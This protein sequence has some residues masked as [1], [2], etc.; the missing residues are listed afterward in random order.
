M[1]WDMGGPSPFVLA[2][3]RK[4]RGHLILM[5]WAI[6]RAHQWLSEKRAKMQHLSSEKELICCIFLSKKL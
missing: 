4:L 2:S 5:P 6:A 3:P 1:I